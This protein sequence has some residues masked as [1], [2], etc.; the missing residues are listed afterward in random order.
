MP[1]I[2]ITIVTHNSAAT[3]DACLGAVM[4]QD[5]GDFTVIAVD[6]ASCDD[7]RQHLGAW[8]G[9]KLR[10]VANDRNTYFARAHNWAIDHTDS[11]FVLTLNPDVMLYPDYL[12]HVVTAFDRSPHIG[13]VNGK[14]LLLDRESMVAE[15][16]LSPP[17]SSV[18][19]DG[20]GLTMR[21]SRR[22]Y[23]RGNRQLARTHCLQPRYI[24]GVDAACG[25]YRRAM[26]DDVVLDGEYFDNDFLIY[27]E[28]VDL[29]WRAQ[30]YGWDSYYTP[31]AVAYHVRGFHLGR[32]RREMATELKRHSVKNGWLLPLKND[33]PR[34]MARCLPWI[35]PYQIKILGGILAVERQSLGAVSDA[36]TL[37][38]TMRRKRRIIQERRRRTERDMRKWFV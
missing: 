33:S 7:S 11:E 34:S 2:A 1:R 5:Y 6:N 8:E 23:L 29:A 4:G 17:E 3:I 36:I 10:V 12:S 31:D 38:P 21:R 28:D 22:P 20:A 37:V 13:S 14:L 27:R 32:G 26:L 25:A 16:L 35:L 18:L 9:P 15:A 30:L 24:F 19:I